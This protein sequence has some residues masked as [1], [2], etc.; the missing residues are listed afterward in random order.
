MSNIK[1]NYTIIMILAV[2]YADKNNKVCASN[3]RPME[4][5]FFELEK[6]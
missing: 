3:R 1:D 5:V 6:K 4:E 2:G